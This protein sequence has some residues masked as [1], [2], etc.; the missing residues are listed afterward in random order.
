MA[1]EIAIN[2][3]GNNLAVRIPQ[4]VVDNLNLHKGDA[5]LISYSDRIITIEL[6][7]DPSTYKSPQ[8]LLDEQIQ[9][10]LH[11]AGVPGY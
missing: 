7:G 9:K 4:F 10:E 2:K 11:D 6:I 1:R 5:A 8:Q 3:W